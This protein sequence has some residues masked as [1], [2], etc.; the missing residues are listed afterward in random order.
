MGTYEKKAFGFD[1][2]FPY[3]YIPQP[4]LIE[5]NKNMHRIIF[6]GLTGPSQATNWSKVAKQRK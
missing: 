2:F 1:S 5:R 6:D 4:N 3:V